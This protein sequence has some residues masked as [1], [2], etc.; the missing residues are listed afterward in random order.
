MMKNEFIERVRQINGGI[1]PEFT[2]EDW[3]IIEKVYNYHP[4]I[5]E[6]TGKDQI[7]YLYFHF[8]MRVI[9]DMY[10]T[11]EEAESLEHK[12]LSLRN[13]LERYT[14]EYDKLKK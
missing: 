14:K 10:P 9:K 4:S 2:N 7:A 6:V 5:N 8:G 1:Y 11:A 3:E 13:E 12:L